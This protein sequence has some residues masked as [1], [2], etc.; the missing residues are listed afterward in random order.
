[1]HRAV[2]GAGYGDEG[3]GL[4]ADGFAADGASLVVRTNGGAQAGHTV[5]T[6]DGRR[7]VF[8][9]FPSGAF[10]GVRGHLSRF[11]V[12]SPIA[13]LAERDELDALGANLS[14]SADPR[15]PVTTPLDM[16]INQIA[17]RARGSGRHGSCGM[18]FGETIER[19]GNAAYAIRASDLGRGDLM[20]RLV[21][22]RDEWVPG[23]L[24][25]LGV[26]PDAVEARNLA[27]DAILDRFVADARAFAGYVRLRGDA[28][29]GSERSIVFEGA[30]GL[31]LDQDYGAFPFVT[32][33]HTGARNVAAV[34]REAGID[35]VEVLY[36]TRAYVTRHG[37]GPLSGEVAR[38]EGFAVVDATNVPNPWQ[39]TIRYA[40]LDLDVLEA[41]IAADLGHLQ[42]LRATACV[43]ISC[44][45][46]ATDRVTWISGAEG[47]S[48]DVAELAGLATSLL[49][50]KGRLSHG[51]T[52]STLSVE[53]IGMPIAC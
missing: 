20:E 34:M 27:N 6:P 28:D 44:L 10:A 48:G 31:M 49:P 46:Q 8:H 45:D 47:A 12:C 36:A 35:G 13:F 52:R 53:R 32:R 2:I 41:A 17:E 7:H 5:T 43:G 26:V 24:A 40:P 51:P 19:D 15:C 22:I 16:M 37:A 30:Q 39:G 9:H 11:F 18:G 42:G 1:M 23:R 25:R 29:L 4:F 33:S 3:K 21:R 50:G 14:V 38:P